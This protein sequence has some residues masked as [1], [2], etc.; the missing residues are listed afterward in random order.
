MIK[1][2]QNKEKHIL[3]AMLDIVSAL[4]SKLREI[5]LSLGDIFRMADS[6]YEG[7]ITK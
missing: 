5:G 4:N 6:N 3:Y 1:D 2:N 7:E